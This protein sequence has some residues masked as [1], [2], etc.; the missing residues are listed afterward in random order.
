VLATAPFP[1]PSPTDTFSPTWLNRG[2]CGRLRLK[3]GWRNVGEAARGVEVSQ[4]RS[5][6]SV[7]LWPCEGCL[8]LVRRS[9]SLWTSCNSPNGFTR[10]SVR[11]RAGELALEGCEGF[12]DLLGLESPVTTTV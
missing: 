4:R 7:R 2:A 11:D 8:W 5:F 12:D 6:S 1:H 3:V 9:I 10:S